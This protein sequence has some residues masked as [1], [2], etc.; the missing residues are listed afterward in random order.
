MAQLEE[1][2]VDTGTEEAS[3]YQ[4]QPLDAAITR[5]Q[6]PN[7]CEAPGYLE[8]RGRASVTRDSDESSVLPV[9][10]RDAPPTPSNE[11]ARSVG[12]KD[13]E[14]E[15][16]KKQVD[17]QAARLHQQQV[18]A[19]NMRA[20]CEKNSDLDL[21]DAVLYAPIPPAAL[22]NI[23]SRSEIGIEEQSASA[24]AGQTAH[25]RQLTGIWRENSIL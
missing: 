16:L 10:P 11:S 19:A 4:D 13:R 5:N 9:R 20:F 17:E 3:P 7:S 23:N 1:A 18:S 22:E 25:Q 24:A 8:V 12:Y 14:I 15:A 6:Y 21:S 2:R